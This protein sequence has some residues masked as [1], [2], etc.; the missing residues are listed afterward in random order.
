[1][2]HNKID[3]IYAVR[4]AAERKAVL[5][6]TLSAHPT[7]EARDALLDAQL[8]LEARTQDAIEACHQCGRVHA[9]DE[10]HGDRAGNVIDVDFR[11][12]DS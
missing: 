11:R 10:P 2:H 5:E 9:D 12:S 4:E 8:T 7:P 1:M 3:A 6:T